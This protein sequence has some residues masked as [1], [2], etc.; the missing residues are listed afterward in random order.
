MAAM[1]AHASQIGADSFFM[2]V[3]EDLI[4]AF[5]GVEEFILEEGDAL[6]GAPDALVLP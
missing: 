5:L 6:P 1:R 4:D 3:P 2:N